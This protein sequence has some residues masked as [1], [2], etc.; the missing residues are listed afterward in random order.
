MRWKCN[1]V[2]KGGLDNGLPSGMI[3]GWAST[4]LLESSLFPAL[5]WI[6]IAWIDF[7]WL[8]PDPDLGGLK[9]HTK[10]EKSEVIHCF[11][12]CYIY[13]YSLL[14][15]RG[16]S[17]ILHFLH[18]SLG[19]NTVYIFNF[20]PQNNSRIRIRIS[21]ETSAAPQHWFPERESPVTRRP[22][23]KSH[24]VFWQFSHCFPVKW[25]NDEFFHGL[26]VLLLCTQCSETPELKV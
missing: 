3:Y 8:D 18:G 20:F 11:M 25:D 15:N 5:L 10:K 13:I 21:I 2:Q 16:F 6:R 23:Q 9:G 4:L 1:E 14:R 19:I 12:C 17:C 22:R 26:P 7:G 24:T